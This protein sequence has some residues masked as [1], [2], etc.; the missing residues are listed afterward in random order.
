VARCI[1]P[2]DAGVLDRAEIILARGPFTVED[3]VALLRR[4]QID[5]LVAKNAGG[6]ATEAKL[7]AAR[8]LGLPVV[9]VQRPPAPDGPTVPTAADA[10]A[11]LDGAL[12]ESADR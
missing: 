9:M 12:L 3:E 7:G 4:H 5:L 11:W 6:S 10:V 2:P 8:R 1:D